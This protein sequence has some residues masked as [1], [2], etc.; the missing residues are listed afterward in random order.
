RIHA[1]LGLRELRP[2]INLGGKPS[3]LP[4]VRWIDRYVGRADKEVSLAADLAAGR[5]CAVVAQSAYGVD[6][7]SRIDVENRLGFRLVAGF[8][9]VAR[10]EQE[11]ADADRGSPHHLALQRQPVL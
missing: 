6:Q 9:I 2:G 5:Q 1:E 8:G 7:R 10:Q 4:A 11:I 3:G